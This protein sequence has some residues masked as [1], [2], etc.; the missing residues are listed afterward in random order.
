MR[1]MRKS[2]LQVVRDALAAG[3]VA[4]QSSR[5]RTLR[6]PQGARS[7]DSTGPM[8]RP[9]RVDFCANWQSS[10]GAICQSPG[11][12]TSRSRAASTTSS[13]TPWRC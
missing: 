6:G 12:I 3:E 2:V 9:L 13:V 8:S 5:V 10:N 4:H 7:A 1:A 11:P